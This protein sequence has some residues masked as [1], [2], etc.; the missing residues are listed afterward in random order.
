MNP[1]NRV[2]PPASAPVRTLALLAI[3]AGCG[4]SDP[5]T[6]PPHGTDAPFDPSPPIRLTLNALADRGPAWLPDGSGILYSAQ[7]E[8]RRDHDVCLAQLPPG[9]GR[10]LRLDCDLTGYGLDSTNAIESPAPAADGRLAFFAVSGDTAAVS[11]D[12]SAI[13][14]A[15]GLNPL[16]GVRRQTVPYTIPGQPT[17][18]VVTQ[19]RWLD[20]G[21]L[22]YVAAARGYNSLTKDT[23]VS[24][25]ALAVIDLSTPGLPSVIPQTEFASGVSPGP[26]PGDVYFTLGGDTRIFRRTLATGDV[27][28]V[29]DFG[30]GAIVRDVHVVGNRMTATVGGRVAFINDPSFGP[31]QYDS[32]GVIHVVDLGTD[33]DQALDDP[34]R[35]F[36]R[37]ALSPS[38]DRIVAEGYPLIITLII[39]P[40]GVFADTTVGRSG[41]LYLLGAP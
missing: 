35:L 24:N 5:F 28:I 18:F 23:I 7:Q 15:P 29:H 9:G 39:A 31:T 32:G 11:P 38:G 14:V 16:S 21:H 22:V 4:H 25:L 36:R 27:S 41:D 10:Q 37:P 3:V 17:H 6:S 34:T 1:S 13:V 40:S 12:M 20:V 26:N 19:L 8:G 30:P 2:F 33:A